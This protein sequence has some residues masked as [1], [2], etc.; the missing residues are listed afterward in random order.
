MLDER[1]GLR[2]DIKPGVKDEIRIKGEIWK[3]ETERIETT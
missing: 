3:D 1:G 2:E